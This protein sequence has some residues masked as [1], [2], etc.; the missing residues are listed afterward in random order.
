[1]PASSVRSLAP[2]TSG[3]SERKA[4]ATT[5][6][7]VIMKTM[8]TPRMI[9]PIGVNAKRLNGSS[10]RSRSIS[11]A[12]MFGGVPI[13]VVVPPKIAPK[14]SGMKNRDGDSPER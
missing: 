2:S 1:M 5:N 9:N 6:P 12:R 13:I 11:A 4:A 3:K 14:E 8:P 7:I 10:P